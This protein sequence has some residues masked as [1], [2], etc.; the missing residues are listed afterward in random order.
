MQ[1][2]AAGCERLHMDPNPQRE[3]LSCFWDHIAVPNASLH[4]ASQV[5]YKFIL[6]PGERSEAVGRELERWKDIIFAAET[7]SN[8]LLTAAFR[9]GGAGLGA[10]GLE[11]WGLGASG[12]LR[13]GRAHHAARER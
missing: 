4:C 10:V 7:R 5:G 6:E 2:G 9:V 13:L 1:N 3:T 11:A 12:L 8:Y